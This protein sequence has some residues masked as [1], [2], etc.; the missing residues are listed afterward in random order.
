MSSSRVAPY[1]NA[2]G[3]GR[4]LILLAN[5]EAFYPKDSPVLRFGHDQAVTPVLG[6][7]GVRKQ[8]L[9]LNGMVHAYRLELIACLPVPQTDELTNP[10]SIEQFAPLHGANS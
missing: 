6:N 9:K 4:Q 2:P 10:I 7:F 5:A 8:I 1:Q 3:V